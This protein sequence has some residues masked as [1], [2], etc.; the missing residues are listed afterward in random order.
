MLSFL[1]PHKP[2]WKHNKNYMKET[3]QVTFRDQLITLKIGSS[4]GCPKESSC[5]STNSGKRER[6]KPHHDQ[7]ITAVTW[8]QNFI[9][10]FLW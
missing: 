6:S 9:I 3:I 7:S 2:H 4:V 5:R 8:Y 1:A 10:Q